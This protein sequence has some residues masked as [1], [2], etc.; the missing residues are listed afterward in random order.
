MIRR[1]GT[2]QFLLTLVLCAA[3]TVVA[4]ARWPGRL[5]SP[6][7]RYLLYSVP[8]EQGVNDGPQLWFENL[9][10][11]AKQM[12]F[13][14]SRTITAQWAPDSSGFFV[15][16]EFSSD[17]TA[18]YIYD[19]R[20]LERLDVGKAILAAYPDARKFTNGHAYF[21]IQ[22]WQNAKRVIVVFHG[23]MDSVSPIVCFESEYNV[24]RDGSVTRLSDK[25]GLPG[26]AP[27]S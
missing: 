18:A 14:I 20:T 17:T 10:S 16:N 5:P 2:A 12:L 26:Q 15:N 9:S 22:R 3:V 1:Y 23:H 7:G 24:G 27:C 21:D 6:D 4:Q 19:A 11:K 8:F 25:S 13:G